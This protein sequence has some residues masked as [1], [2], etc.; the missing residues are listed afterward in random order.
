MVVVLLITVI[1]VGMGFSVL[2]LVQKQ[3]TGIQYN[4]GNSTEINLLR[5]SLW[6][7]LA[8]FE[9]ISYNEQNQILT[10]ESEIE[11][12]NYKFSKEMIIKGKDTFNLNLEN[13]IFYFDNQ[14]RTNGDVDAVNIR[15][16]KE[17]GEEK[18]FV[19]KSNSATTYMNQ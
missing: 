16:G 19:F 17:Y 14:E 8:R 2:S 9:I 15:F 10:C 1:V 18:L 7:D 12:V 4:Y 11:A 6:V 13:Y 3:M 5:Q